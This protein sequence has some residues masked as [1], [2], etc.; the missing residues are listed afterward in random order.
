MLGDIQIYYLADK[1]HLLPRLTD[2]FIAEWEPYYGLNGPGNAEDDLRNSMNREQLPICLI[3]L[4][5]EKL[6]GTV[7]LKEKSVSHNP[8]LTPWCSALLV[9]PTMRRRGIGT[10]LISALERE[11]KRLD[12]RTLYMSTDTANSIAEARGWKAIG[13]AESMRGIVTVYKLNLGLKSS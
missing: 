6:L 10:A 2:L 1:P 5:E 8:E 9:V 12:C 4:R 13:K 7:S 11:A 3:A